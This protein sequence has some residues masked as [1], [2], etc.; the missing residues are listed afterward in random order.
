MSALDNSFLRKVSLIKDKLDDG[1]ATSRAND[2]KPIGETGG[3]YEVNISLSDARWSNAN[4]PLQTSG[5]GIVLAVQG[6]TPGVALN[7]NFNSSGSNSITNF[8]PGAC[9]KAPFS[10]LW[11]SKMADCIPGTGNVRLII[12]TRN[13]VDYSELF[14]TI[15]GGT[16]V[17]GTCGPAGATTQAYNTASRGANAPS[18]STDGV[19]LTGVRGF[20]VT[21]EL[22]SSTIAGGQI[23]LWWF[24]P[25][26]SV[27]ARGPI[28]EV[29]DTGA[30]RCVTSEYATNVPAGR[31]YAELV[32][33][34]AA[35]GA[36]VGTVRVT[37]FG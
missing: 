20:R 10:D 6:T 37:A 30:I 35:A 12:L 8:R 13:D 18:A 17:V 14:A 24:D 28:F 25:T 23:R 9:F 2:T 4:L 11:L 5:Y 21:V 16:S 15:A 19:S 31:V 34:T 22:A 27:W 29:L 26:G 32:S 33:V 36:P 1:G 3:F 7:L